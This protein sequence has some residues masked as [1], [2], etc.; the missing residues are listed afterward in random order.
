MKGIVTKVTTLV[1]NK[2]S[3]FTRKGNGFSRGLGTGLGKNFAY[4]RKDLEFR[5]FAKGSN[6]HAICYW[7]RRRVRLCLSLF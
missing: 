5:I 6:K 3:I 1:T 7:F 4:I 2:I